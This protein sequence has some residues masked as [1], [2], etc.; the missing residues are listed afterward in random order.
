MSMTI[1][2]RTPP[3]QPRKTGLVVVV[4]LL[5]LVM[6]MTITRRTLSKQ[7]RL[8]LPDSA[9]RLLG[10]CLLNRPVVY[11]SNKFDHSN[12]YTGLS[13]VNVS[14]VSECVFIVVVTIS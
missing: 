8:S 1:T 12:I 6:S 11:A 10:C 4:V 13:C 9:R 3:K 14:C 5:L 7:P 2:R